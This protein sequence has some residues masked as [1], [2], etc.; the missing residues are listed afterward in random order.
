MNRMGS[1]QN[2]YQVWAKDL[3]SRS[4]RAAWVAGCQTA[5]TDRQH[6]RS[7]SST[8]RRERGAAPVTAT[9]ALP[10]Q[11]KAPHMARKTLTDF[12]RVILSVCT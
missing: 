5:G 4:L 8:P 9:A 6:I 11:E 7:Q 12:H 2:T 3:S 1:I 10:R